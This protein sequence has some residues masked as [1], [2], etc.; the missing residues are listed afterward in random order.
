[1]IAHISLPFR[2]LSG[3]ELQLMACCGCPRDP[4]AQTD[5]QTDAQTCEIEE[6]LFADGGSW[7]DGAN[8]PKVPLSVSKMCSGPKTIRARKG[9][10]PPHARSAKPLWNPPS[11]NGRGLGSSVYV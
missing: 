3:R 6:R 2:A 11:A 5:A 7:L 4:P 9:S 1:M 10:S 8:F